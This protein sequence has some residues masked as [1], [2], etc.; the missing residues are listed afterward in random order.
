MPEC[1]RSLLHYLLTQRQRELPPAK[2][3][4][5][6]RT[7]PQARTQSTARA[8]DSIPE[9]CDHGKAEEIQEMRIQILKWGHP[10]TDGKDMCCGRGNVYK[11]ICS[12]SLVS[13][14]YSICI[15]NSL[16]PRAKLLHCDRNWSWG[17][18]TKRMQWILARWFPPPTRVSE[19]DD[20]CT[21]WISAL[22]ARVRPAQNPF[23]ASVLSVVLC[24]W[25]CA[26][27]CNSCLE[28]RWRWGDNPKKHPCEQ[29]WE[30][31]QF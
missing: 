26:H 20:W 14:C 22:W 23:N 29:K 12:Y 31:T 27:H 21:G 17:E 10:L 8:A 15:H 16:K 30:Q 25:V 3:S 1:Y 5:P 24:L 7:R 11:I 28:R 2:W 9:V 13:Q 6:N 4:L 18:I 19:K